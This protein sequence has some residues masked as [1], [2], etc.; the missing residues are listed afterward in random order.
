MLRLVRALSGS[1]KAL[2]AE[3]SARRKPPLD[4]TTIID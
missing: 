4:H 1:S 3:T 2:A